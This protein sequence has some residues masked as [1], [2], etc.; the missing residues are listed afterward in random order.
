ML[1]EVTWAIVN[2]P[3]SAGGTTAPDAFERS[4]ARYSQPHRASDAGLGYSASDFSDEVGVPPRLKWEYHRGVL[5]RRL[6]WGD[7]TELGVRGPSPINWVC[8]QYR[9]DQYFC[10]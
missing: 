3:R 6:I 1:P 2:W 9:P 8:E 7:F 10:G 4:R 5:K